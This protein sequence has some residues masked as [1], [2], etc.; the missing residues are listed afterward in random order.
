[1]QAR[2]INLLTIALSAALMSPLAMAQDQTTDATAQTS[3]AAQTQTTPPMSDMA[4]GNT[5]S[6][7]TFTRLDIN[8]DGRISAAEAK[9]DTTLRG[10]FASMDVDH[11][12]YVSNAEYSAGAASSSSKRSTMG[13]AD[14][15]DTDSS[16]NSDTKDS[17]ET[18]KQDDTDS[19]K[20]P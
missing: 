20:K 3:T 13:N 5:A 16:T 6:N 11:D 7:A 15:S 14:W 2:T 17:M 8:G 4:T 9:A 10:G 12:G 19:T 1:M 18:D